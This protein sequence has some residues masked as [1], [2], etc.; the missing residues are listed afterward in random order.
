MVP[1]KQPRRMTLA[2]ADAGVPHQLLLVDGA[3]H[4]DPAFHTTSVL[5]AVTGWLTTPWP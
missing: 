4:E 5:G 2:L 1:L 3:T